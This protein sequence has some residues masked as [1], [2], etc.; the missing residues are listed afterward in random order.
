M[1][2]IAEGAFKGLV[3]VE[4]QFSVV[5]IY[6]IWTVISIHES[7]R[8]DACWD[9]ILSKLSYE[10]SKL[11]VGN[12]GMYGTVHL[13]Q[14]FVSLTE[15]THMRIVTFML[16]AFIDAAVDFLF[17]V[18]ESYGRRINWIERDM[19]YDWHALAPSFY[20]HCFI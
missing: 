4:E 20:P 15:S 10:R 12:D 13:L 1:D 5:F 11:R 2:L 6:G 7:S 14:L 18:L 19:V 8:L 17:P 3:L 16:Y 9:K